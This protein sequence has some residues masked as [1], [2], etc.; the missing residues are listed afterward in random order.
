M[1]KLRKA[2]KRKA[3]KKE[4]KQGVT[5]F[6]Q[7]CVHG[8]TTTE[9]YDNCGEGVR[10]DEYSGCLVLQRKISAE[11]YDELIYI[12]AINVKAWRYGK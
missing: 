12:P 11:M 3:P 1:S 6:V 8:F 10:Y 5:I 2:A 4:Q 9:Q 7:F